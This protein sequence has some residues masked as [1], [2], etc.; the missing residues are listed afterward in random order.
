MESGA[1]SG[2]SRNKTYTQMIWCSSNPNRAEMFNQYT[3]GQDQNSSMVDDPYINNLFEESAATL[4]TEPERNAEMVKEGIQYVISQAYSFVPPTPY[5][6]TG[7]W[8]WIKAYNGEKTPG[9]WA[10]FDTWSKYLW[11]DQGLKNSMGY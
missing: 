1:M 10:A 9:S 5:Y 6:H 8:P 2:V 4:M 11:I 3:A 7:W